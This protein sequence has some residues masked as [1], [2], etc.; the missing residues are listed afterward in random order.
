MSDSQK[1]QRPRCSAHEA[2]GH[3]GE[4]VVDAGEDGE[5]PCHRHDEVKVR[6]DEEGVVQVLVERG[7]GKD[8]AGDAAGDEEREEAE[9]KEQ[10][11]RAAKAAAPESTDPTKDL[12]GGRDGDGHGGEPEGGAGVGIHAADEHVM[13]PDDE[14]EQADEH[15]G[16]GHHA[17]ADDGA[18]AEIRR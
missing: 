16:G 12:G 6:D 2:A 15:S 5:R 8:G 4:P 14:A 1:C 11:S 10:G 13:T 7:Q 17:V 3:Q 9:G 18:A